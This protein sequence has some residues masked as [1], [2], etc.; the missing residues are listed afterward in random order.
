[1]AENQGRQASLQDRTTTEKLLVKIVSVKPTG[2]AIPMAAS[3]VAG[4]VA[5]VRKPMQPATE[6]AS[7]RA[8][9]AALSDGNVGTMPRHLFGGA[10]I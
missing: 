1:M 7:L 4:R 5:R 6:Q 9:Q 2:Q 8:L 10:F 3:R